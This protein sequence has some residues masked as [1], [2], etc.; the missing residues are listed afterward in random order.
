LGD[1][2]SIKHLVDMTINSSY[3]V[4]PFEY[5]QHWMDEHHS[6]E[7]IFAEASEGFTLVVQCDG[8]IIGTGNVLH[9]QIQ[10]LF[11]H[12]E[13]QRRGYGTELI[14]RLEDQARMEGVGTLRLSALT[15]S[16]QFFEGLGY[17]IIS[18]N[19]FKDDNLRQFKYYNME[20]S[21]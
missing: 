13:Y 21:I 1:L 6:K 7:H 2:D 17:Q 19:Q 8:K 3:S 18:E 9:E 12:P 5:R 15:H 11:V 14:R 4:F 20:K 16:K 10:S